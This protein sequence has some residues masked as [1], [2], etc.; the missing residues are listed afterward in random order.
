MNKINKKSHLSINN[1]TRPFD[2]YVATLRESIKSHHND[3]TK[4]I[5]YYL[6]REKDLQDKN[7]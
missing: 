2:G 4:Y 3:V 7:L 1:D 5:I 6:M